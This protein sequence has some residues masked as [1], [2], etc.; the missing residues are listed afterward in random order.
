M[1][2]SFSILYKIYSRKTFFKVH[3]LFF[4]I[5]SC[6]TPSLG[7]VIGIPNCDPNLS[8]SELISIKSGDL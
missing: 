1:N 8:K 5:Y 3:V 2:I 4:V 6:S 7:D